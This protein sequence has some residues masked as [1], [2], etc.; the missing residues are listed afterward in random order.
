[1]ILQ[2]ATSE[3]ADCVIL[4][5]EDSKETSD[6]HV[7]MF[8]QHTEAMMEEIDRMEEEVEME[9]FVEELVVDIDSSDKQNSL[10][11][12]EYIHELYAFYKTTEVKIV[13]PLSAL[14][15]FD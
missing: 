11:V 12:V 14:L 10:A 2:S 6:F 3:L 1:M 7:P 15:N 4:D 8:V 5:A 13:S 9:D